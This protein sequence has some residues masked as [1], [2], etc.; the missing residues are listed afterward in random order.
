MQAPLEML[1]LNWFFYN[2]LNKHYRKIVTAGTVIYITVL[3]LEKTL[4]HYNSYYFQSLSYTVANLF[5][6][7]YITL[8]FM[9]LMNSEKILV[10]KKLTVFWIVCGLLVF[11][12][13]TFPFY[14]LYNE[15]SKNID[16]FIP[17]A[18][19]ATS[20]NY[21]MYLLFTIG[22]VWGKPH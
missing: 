21:C 20:L 7:I 14:G 15:L 19:V 11:Y 8:F 4:F 13:G 12:L 9:E 16:I 18:W 3:I 17:V 5:I 10:F 6:L 1:F 2:T 22:F